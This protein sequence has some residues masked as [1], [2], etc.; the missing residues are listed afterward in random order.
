[1]RISF[2]AKLEKFASMGE[3]TGWTYFVIPKKAAEKLIPGRKT[4]YRVKGKIDNYKIE[5]VAMIPFGEGNFI[6]AF[7]ATMRKGTGKKF[8][9]SIS[10]ELEVD[11]FVKEIDTEF[12]ECLAFE[13]EAM[14]FF[15]AM[16]PSHRQYYSNWI[17]SAKTE[18]TKTKRIALAV[19]T[20]AKKMNYGEM[21]RSQKA[22]KLN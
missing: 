9:D 8:G 10:L 11:L 2:N 3:K 19:N 22:D 18:G 1:M 17:S 7:N 13:P 6:I 21:L 20:L 5:F 14:A 12:L 15:D 4:S 16:P